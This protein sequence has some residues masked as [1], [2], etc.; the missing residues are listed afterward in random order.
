MTLPAKLS[1]MAEDKID[2]AASDYEGKY[3]HPRHWDC[4]YHSGDTEKHFAEGAKWALALPEVTELV[5]LLERSLEVR[6]FEAPEDAEVK[7]LGKRIGFGA[8]MDAAVKG[9]HKAAKENGY[10]PGGAFTVGHCH[11]TVESALAKW[12]AFTKGNE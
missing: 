10:P 9:W 5:E 4:C 1:E 7:A 12:K 2:Q 8:L 3:N 6:N 11:A